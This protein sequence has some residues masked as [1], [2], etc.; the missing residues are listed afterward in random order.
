MI[1]AIILLS[2]ALVAALIYISVLQRRH[3]ADVADKARLEAR[4]LT[5]EDAGERQRSFYE[6]AL[7]RQA[8]E[9]RR[10]SEQL[11]ERF[12]ELAAKALVDNSRS[13][14]EQNKRS[15]DSILAPVR[16]NIE[17]F[18]KTIVERYDN[19]ARER[20]AL[21]ERVRELHD[22]NIAIGRQTQRLTDALQ[23][24]SRMQGDWGEMILDNILSASGLR[25]D[26][27]YTVQ[28]TVTDAEGRRL[29]PDVV[30][31]Y[32]QGHRLIIDSKVSIQ[33]YLNM[34]AA[35]NDNDRER[36]AKAHIQSVRKHIGELR[37]KNYQQAVGTPAFDYV[38][39]FIPHE[40]AFLAAVDL[41]SALWQTAYESRVLIISP[42]HLMS[43]VKLIEQMWCQE[44]QNNNALAIADEAGK[45]LDK[46][47]GFLEDMERIDR[48]I[49]TARDAWE[50]AIGKLSKGPGNLIGKARKLED[51]GAR[52][53]RRLPARYDEAADD[54]DDDSDN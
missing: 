3:N 37:S 1:A 24:N 22:L 36:F 25:R 33:D 48:G 28:E 32:P 6:D 15:L 29:R 27:E 21:G 30:I 19:E 53:K 34:L 14:E 16:D 11:A 47:R 35:N 43:I 45:M 13:L 42:A 4:A 18:R 52:A 31:N 50:A 5:A 49:N 17:N 20:Y 38:L 51:L 40:G 46:F 26:F 2:V 12:S 9:A 39:M 23:G 10:A 8:D 44:R 41:D 54:D 7:A